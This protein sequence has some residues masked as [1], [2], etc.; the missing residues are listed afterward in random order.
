MK[1]VAAPCKTQD[2]HKL[3]ANQKV[4]FKMAY[5]QLNRYN[6]RHRERD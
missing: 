5:R 2:F 6:N 3:S 1:S 4:P